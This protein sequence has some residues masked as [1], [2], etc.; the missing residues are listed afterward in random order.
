MS[1][2]THVLCTFK[3]LL[4]VAIRH[5]T[6]HITLHMLSV[7]SGLVISVISEGKCIRILTST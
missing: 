5:L 6:I 4:V 3:M 1:G 7:Y 2:F